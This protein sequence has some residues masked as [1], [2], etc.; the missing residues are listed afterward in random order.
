MLGNT[1]EF[2]G[3]LCRT[4]F[5]CVAFGHAVFGGMG[6]GNDAVVTVASGY[7]AVQWAHMTC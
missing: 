5:R 7:R 3:M 4:L 2:W 1:G 6:V